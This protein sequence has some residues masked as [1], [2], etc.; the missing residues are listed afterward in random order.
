MLILVPLH[1]RGNG[2]AKEAMIVDSIL[3]ASEPRNGR[4]ARPAAA[5]KTIP[6]D[7]DGGESNE[8]GL[9]YRLAWTSFLPNPL[10]PP[11]NHK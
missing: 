9:D 3:D 1:V 7:D 11:K 6:T 5:I 10:W 8:T 4:A 2:C